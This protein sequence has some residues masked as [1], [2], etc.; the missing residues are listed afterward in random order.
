MVKLA[1]FLLIVGCRD[2]LERGTKT[3]TAF[4]ERHLVVDKLMRMA[5]AKNEDLRPDDVR[6]LVLCAVGKCNEARELILNVTVGEEIFDI[7]C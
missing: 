1:L 4:V 6:E 3:F 7:S 2:D 5:E